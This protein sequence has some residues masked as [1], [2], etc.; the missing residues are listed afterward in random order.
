[1]GD[2]FPVGNCFILTGDY[3]KTVITFTCLP[4]VTW[5][6]SGEIAFQWG[7]VLNLEI[8]FQLLFSVGDR[9]DNLFYM[10][11][12]IGRLQGETVLDTVFQMFL[13]WEV[14]GDK[15]VVFFFRLLSRESK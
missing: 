1:M 13:Q 11:F 3:L 14:E 10:L 7:T 5:R 8:V 12:S 4:V 9:G 2:C 6:F 15:L